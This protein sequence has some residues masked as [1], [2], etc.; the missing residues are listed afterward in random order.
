MRR[1]R[2]EGRAARRPRPHR[3]AIRRHPA[4]ADVTDAE[5]QLAN[6]GAVE[7]RQRTL[8]E[9]GNVTQAA[10]DAA[11]ASRDTAAARLAQGK[12][13]LQKA[14]DELGYATLKAE[15]TGW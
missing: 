9:G 5:A 6:A 10:L 3:A 14:T 2:A 13:A 7:A 11:V 15:S 4:R 1:P 12:A 8:F